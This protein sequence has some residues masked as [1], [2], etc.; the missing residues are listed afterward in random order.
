MIIKQGM[1]IALIGV[2]IGLALASALT[3]VIAGFL[4]GV[5][6]RDPLVFA[7]VPVVLFVVALVGVWLPARR[8]ARVE[9]LVA[10]RAD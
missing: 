1:T 9:P 6:T 8:A 2:V 3:R 7:V 4:Y 5:T 10:L